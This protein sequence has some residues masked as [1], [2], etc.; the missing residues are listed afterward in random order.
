MKK[1]AELVSSDKDVNCFSED[2]CEMG[3]SYGTVWEG[4]TSQKRTVES[5][6]LIM[7]TPL[8]R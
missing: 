7:K 2:K 5:G 6:S 8:R 1:E 4:C 3:N